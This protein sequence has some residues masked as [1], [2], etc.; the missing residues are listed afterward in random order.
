MIFVA[1]SLSL[2]L[3]PH[4]SN[5]NTRIKLHRSLHQQLRLELVIHPSIHPSHPPCL[6]TL[7]HTT[8]LTLHSPLISLSPLCRPGGNTGCLHDPLPPPL[9][10][11]YPYSSTIPTLYSPPH[12]GLSSLC[13]HPRPSILDPRSS[14]LDPQP[15]TLDPLTSTLTLTLTLPLTLTLAPFT[16]CFFPVP[17][18]G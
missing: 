6:L 17:F 16:G 18:G 12:P 1:V 3:N 7:T 8:T 10:L 15:S 14:T 9:S 13:S 11:S 5:R 4:N 2:S